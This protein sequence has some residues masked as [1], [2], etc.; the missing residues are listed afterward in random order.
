MANSYKFSERYKEKMSQVGEKLTE[1]EKKWYEYLLKYDEKVFI[2]ILGEDKYQTT[3]NKVQEIIDNGSSSEV[4]IYKKNE[5]Y[6][7][8]QKILYEFLA[9]NDFSYGRKEQ[10]KVYERLLYFALDDN[11]KSWM[12]ILEIFLEKNVSEL[13]KKDHVVITDKRKAEYDFLQNAI[14]DFLEC[15]MFEQSL[16]KDR[17]KVVNIV[18]EQIKRFNKKEVWSM[19]KSI[20]MDSLNKNRCII[21]KSEYYTELLERDIFGILVSNWKKWAEKEGKNNR[22]REKQILLCQKKD[23]ENIKVIKTSF[24]RKMKEKYINWRLSDTIDFY[25]DFLCEYVFPE[26]EFWKIVLDNKKCKQRYLD[27]MLL[28]S[29]QGVG[30][31]YEGDLWTSN[32]AKKIENAI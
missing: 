3:L 20:H 10:V 8:I 12:D 29:V 7:Y 16:L 13:P 6:N 18:R 32:E 31:A 19:R 17:K 4:E 26:I 11:R 15:G 30:G 24:L 25:F 28:R 1:D 23:L 14:E 5:I 27:N 21:Q 2:E 22:I 9:K